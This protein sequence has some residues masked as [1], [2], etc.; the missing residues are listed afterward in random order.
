MLDLNGRL[1]ALR[2]P[3]LLIR[4]ARI[5]TRDYCRARHLPRLLGCDILPRPPLAVLQLIEQEQ[6]LDQRRQGNDPGYPLTRHIEVL[7]A[8]MGEAQLLSPNHAASD[9]DRTEAKTGP[10]PSQTQNIQA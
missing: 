9:Q 7:I 3:R 4:A 10:C 8:L 2:R 1:S 6:D 5:G